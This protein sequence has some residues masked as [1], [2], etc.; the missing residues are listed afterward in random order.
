MSDF[1]ITPI[2]FNRDPFAKVD[3]TSEMAQQV[4]R[5]LDQDL[6]VRLK[7]RIEAP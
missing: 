1:F 3:R 4:R 6:P 2:I 5:P 7:C